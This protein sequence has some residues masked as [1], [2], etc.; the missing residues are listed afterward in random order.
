MLLVWKEAESEFNSHRLAIWA[1]TTFLCT[2]CSLCPKYLLPTCSF[3][4]CP[5][6]SSAGLWEAV[7]DLSINTHPVPK[8]TH[9]VIS[10][11]GPPG[12]TVQY[13]DYLI[14]GLSPHPHTQDSKLQ[15]D[16]SFT[17]FFSRPYLPAW[18]TKQIFNKWLFQWLN[19]GAGHV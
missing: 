8:H 12:Y 2:E 9:T 3:G 14:M 4:K 6:S 18:H 17:L 5:M 15:K 7:L 10:F 1:D 19:E 13:C 11:L 16:K